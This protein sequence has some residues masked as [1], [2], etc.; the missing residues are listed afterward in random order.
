MSF[1][2]KFKENWNKEDEHCAHCGNVSKPALGLNR[3]NM[4]RLISFKANMSDFLTLIM[5][6]M[7]ILAALAYN[8]VK[9]E[10]DKCESKNNVNTIQT[11][12]LSSLWAHNQTVNLNNLPDYYNS[13][14]N[15]R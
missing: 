15:G 3:Q 9:A 8:D 2:E 6:A 12:G 5:I 13:T 11:G 7:V 4:K 14:Q 10:L 1:K